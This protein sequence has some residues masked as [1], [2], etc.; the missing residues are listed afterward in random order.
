MPATVAI[1]DRVLVLGSFD[2]ASEYPVT[3]GSSEWY[4]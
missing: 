2:P 3:G 4:E 1:D